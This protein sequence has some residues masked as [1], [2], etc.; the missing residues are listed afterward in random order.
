MVVQDQTEMSLNLNHYPV[1]AASDA[2]HLF[3]SGAATPP[4]QEGRWPDGLLSLLLF[5][6]CDFQVL[7]YSELHNPAYQVE[8]DRLIQ[9]KLYGALSTFISGQLFLELLRSPR[10]RI[11]SNMFLVS[12]KEDQIAV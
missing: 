5:S 4:G 11:E 12:G 7:R 9:R 3:L 8:R 10:R 1:C 6:F 2:S